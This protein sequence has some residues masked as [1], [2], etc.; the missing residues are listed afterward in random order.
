MQSYSSIFF[1]LI[2][3]LLAG[4]F[5]IHGCSQPS[6]DQQRQQFAKVS[7]G[8]TPELAEYMQ[9]IRR[10][11]HKLSLSIEARNGDLADFYMHELQASALAV[12]QDVPGYEGYDIAYF[13]ELM[14]DPAVDTLRTS[15]NARDWD[16]I[17]KNLD[18]LINS[19]NTCH[20]ATG[21]GFINVTEGV[22]K[23]PYNQVFEPEE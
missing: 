3:T 1:A 17:D 9:H 8:Q 12:K 2:T 23:N 6:E 13:T 18:N 11:T 20:N 15:L 10:Y 7:Q 5:F 21:H 16:L 14:F 4:A 22:D 19:C